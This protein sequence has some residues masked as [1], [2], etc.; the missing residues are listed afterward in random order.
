MK[1]S[2]VR[3]FVRDLEPAKTFYAE[4]LGLPLKLHGASFG[5]C[6]FDVGGADLLLETIKPEEPP[7][8]QALVGRFTGVAFDVEDIEAEHERLAERGVVFTGL[9]EKQFWGGIMA[10]FKDPE[11]NELQ[12]VQRPAL[13]AR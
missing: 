3:I 6:Q 1:L 7:E 9:P 13:L 10:T 5:F 12:L 4:V 11:G 2:A 8:D